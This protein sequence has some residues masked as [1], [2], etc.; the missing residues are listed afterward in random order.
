MRVI[1][2]GPNG[3][4]K[5]TLIKHLQD[6]YALTYYHSNNKTEN[7]LE[8]H[9]NLIKDNNVI[10]D[11]FNLGEIVYPVIYGRQTK[12]KYQEH[13]TLFK[14]LNEMGAMFILFIDSN[15]KTLNQRLTSRGDTEE[16]L[17]NSSIENDLFIAIKD[18]LEKKYKDMLIVVDVDKVPDQIKFIEDIIEIK[19]QNNELF[20]KDIEECLKRAN[21]MEVILLWK[22]MI[23]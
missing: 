2:E 1:V 15:G 14:Q 20:K 3:I 16:V 9:Q 7:T 5:S 21:T 6:K 12:M 17:L 23:Q 19:S 8:Y 11:R 18:Y 13:E 22:K 10:C 4:G